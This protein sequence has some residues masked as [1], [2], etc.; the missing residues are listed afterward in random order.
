MV[1]SWVYPPLRPELA[2]IYP[3]VRSRVVMNVAL[4]TRSMRS[5]T[6]GMGYAFPADLAFK[7]QYNQRTDE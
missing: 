5:S 7:R 6:L 1:L 3:F 2:S 4:P